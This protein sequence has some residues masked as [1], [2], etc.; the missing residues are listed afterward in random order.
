MARVEFDQ[1]LE[2]LETEI[3]IMASTVEAAIEKSINSL[4]KQDMDLAKD[5][6]KGDDVIDKMCGDI[7]DLC[8]S[9][10]RRQAPL[11]SDLREIV[12]C[13]YVIE[14]LERI[15]DYAEGIA[16]LTIKIGVRPLPTDLVIIPKMSIKTIEILRM[17]TD[18][19]LIKDPK[20][21]NSKY[22]KIRNQDDV[23]DD[24]NTD[25]RGRLIEL[26]KNKPHEIERAT[27]LLWVAHNLERIADRGLNIAE[28]SMQLVGN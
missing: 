9:I 22:K 28:R 8:M 26:M 27:Y 12:S 6:I 7:E 1:E 14:E 18:T 17:S 11:A 3:K 5:V 20:E 24:L 23:I 16:V 10:L 19:F 13:M 25:V 4:L 21:V 2:R 15:G